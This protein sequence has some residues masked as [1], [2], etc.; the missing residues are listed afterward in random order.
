ML[1]SSVIMQKN[2]H[3]ARKIRDPNRILQQ[4]SADPAVFHYRKEE[5]TNLKV[6]S[7][8]YISDITDHTAEMVFHDAEDCQ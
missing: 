4:R 1:A 3:A 7:V 5:A 6:K 2:M 8:C